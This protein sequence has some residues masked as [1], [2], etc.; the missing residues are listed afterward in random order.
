MKEKYTYNG[1]NSS[2]IIEENKII[3]FDKVNDIT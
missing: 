2:V 3:S 1:I